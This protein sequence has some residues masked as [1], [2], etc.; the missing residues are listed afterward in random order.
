MARARVHQHVNPLAK[1]FRELPVEPLDLSKV[2]GDPG[3]PLFIDIGCARG[4]FLLGM[5]REDEGFNYLGLEIR[6]PLVDDANKIRDEEGIGNLNY[7][8]CNATFDLGTLLK[9][10]PEGILKRVTIQFPDPWFKKKHAKRRMVKGNMVEVI[11]EHLAAD[12]FILLQ[13]DV[14]FVAEEMRETFGNSG[15]FDIEEIDSNPLQLKTEREI[16]V[17]NKGL[18]VLRYVARLKR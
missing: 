18:P 1:Y 6:E 13:T 12:G 10:L 2:F 5:A 7:E 15:L 11:A 17:E 16:A 14:E 3:L 9:D 8:F 4:R